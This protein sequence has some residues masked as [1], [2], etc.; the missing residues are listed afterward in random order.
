MTTPFRLLPLTDEAIA[1]LLDKVPWT[2]EQT[3]AAGTYKGQ[4]ADVK[5]TA[6]KAGVILL[7]KTLAAEYG[8]HGIRANCICPGAIE[9][10]GTEGLLPM[11]EIEYIAQGRAGRPEEIA[12][13]ALFLASAESSYSNGASLVVDG[14]WTAEVKIPFKLHTNPE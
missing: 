7:T 2:M 11:L 10:A 14:G 3:I 8:R 12:Q 9:T 5:W 13:A 4:D 6:S 1:H